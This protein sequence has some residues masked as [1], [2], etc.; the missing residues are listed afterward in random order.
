MI[1]LLLAV[2]AQSVPATPG[3]APTPLGAIGE[4]A[5]PARGCAAYLW[6][7]A[8]R[9]LVAMAVADPGS[10]RIRLGGKTIDLARSG[11]DG[12]GKFGFAGAIAY[13]GGDVT[14]RLSMDIVQQDGLI[15]GARVP[16]GSLEI[17]RPGQDGIVV[18]VAGLIGCRT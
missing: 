15:A 14:A 9:Q 5:L 6:N 2:A 11:G 7:P 13:Q 18:A 10:L 16:T 3:V 12:A 4:Q 8:D 17:D 1:A